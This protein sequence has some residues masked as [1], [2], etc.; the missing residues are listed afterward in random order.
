MIRKIVAGATLLCLS[1]FANAS[2]VEQTATFGV[3]TTDFSQTAS[4]D[5]F[6]D[7]GGSLLLQSVTISMESD[8]NGFMRAESLDALASTITSTFNAS[9]TLNGLMMELLSDT[10]NVVNTFEASAFDCVIDYAGTSGISYEDI[11][12][13]LGSSA[14]FTDSAVLSSF[15]GNGL[16]DLLFNA[17]ATTAS[18]GPGNVATWSQSSANGSLTVTYDFVDAQSVSAPFTFALVLLGSALLLLRRRNS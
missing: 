7:M 18:T 12:G 8:I 3:S 17:N 13:T 2:F 10:I 5:Q 15:T 14:V 4:I 9:L 6:D 1:A 16:L 11:G